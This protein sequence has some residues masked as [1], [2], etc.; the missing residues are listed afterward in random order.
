MRE[1]MA[2]MRMQMSAEEHVKLGLQVFLIDRSDRAVVTLQNVQARGWL[3]CGCRFVLKGVSRYV[4]S[5]SPSDSL[6]C[7]LSLDGVTFFE[8]YST[9]PSDI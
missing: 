1:R 6:R 9:L 7:E 8:L 2:E 4:R 3:Q 5:P